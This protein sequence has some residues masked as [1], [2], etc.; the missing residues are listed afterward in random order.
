MRE[1]RASDL[2]I[3]CHTGRA[4][5]KER[6]AI[7][8]GP[9]TAT[10]EVTR[11]HLGA[12]LGMREEYRREMQCQI[13][14]DSWHERGFT[15]SWLLRVDGE[16]AG[17]GSVGG[18]PGDP[19]DTLKE[20]FVRPPFRAEATSLFER[21]V[22]VSSARAVEAQT[23]DPL[24]LL[25]LQDFA[26]TSSSDTILFADGH[27]TALV[28][29]V[30]GTSF[31]PLT[32]PDRAHAFEHTLEPV[33]EWGVD[34][35]GALVATGGLMFHYNPPYADIYMEVAGTHRRMGFGAYLVQ[36]LKRVA[37]EM[38]CIPAARCGHTNVGS[39]RTLQRAGMFPCARVMRGV[40]ADGAT[41]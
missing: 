15:T 34:V 28:P 40:L 20:F 8:V 36:E 23:N 7:T 5:L 3:G 31:R 12:I 32:K 39:R 6:N 26:V 1:S 25:M 27:T 21:L 10:I 17:Y 19:K 2:R 35:D 9:V 24:L 41:P 14:H 37:Y 16:I 13:V 33:G 11:A 38:G 30:P 4:F 29:P 22:S 18:A